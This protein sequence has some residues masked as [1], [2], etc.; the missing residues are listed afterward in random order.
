MMILMVKLVRYS[1]LSLANISRTKNIKSVFALVAVKEYPLMIKRE[2]GLDFYFNECTPP[3]LL[4]SVR[5]CLLHQGRGR[6][7][8]LLTG[9]L[10]FEAGA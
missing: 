10:Q 6:A 2:T 8:F 5:V 4:S 7:H 9:V 1:S 3:T